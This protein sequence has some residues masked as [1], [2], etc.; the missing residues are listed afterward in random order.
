MTYEIEVAVQEGGSVPV[1][2]LPPSPDAPL[3]RLT[4]SAEEEGVRR[5]GVIELYADYALAVFSERDAESGEYRELTRDKMPLEAGF[6]RCRP[7]S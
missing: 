4:L 5:R 7:S 2:Q 3:L 1:T 6:F